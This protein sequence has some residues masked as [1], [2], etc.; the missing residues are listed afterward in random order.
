LCRG[1]VGITIVVMETQ[2]GPQVDTPAKPTRRGRAEGSKATYF[3]PG[4]PGRKKA[5]A[6]AGPV[7]VDLLADMK[8]VYATS[9]SADVT[10]GQR[11][12]R[13]WYKRDPAG[14][15]D[16]LQKELAKAAKAGPLTDGS[17][18]AE[19]ADADQGT[20]RALEEV[21]RWLAEYSQKRRLEE[22]KFVRDGLCAC[23]GQRPIPG[24]GRAGEIVAGS[25]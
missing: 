3:Q 24:R 9:P 18:M 16:V 8:H 25:D 21:N 7:V 6:P 17:A 22:E 13:Q 20:S 2:N 4:H 14:F 15:M 12:C 10:P 5:V 23:C 11:K 1:V 19:S